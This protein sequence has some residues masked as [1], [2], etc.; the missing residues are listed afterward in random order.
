MNVNL[1]CLLFDEYLI[2]VLDNPPFINED[3]LGAEFDA[4]TARQSRP[5]EIGI[6]SRH[7][8]GIELRRARAVGITATHR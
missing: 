3:T 6:M 1:D 4:T 8:S 7:A 2:L 5:L